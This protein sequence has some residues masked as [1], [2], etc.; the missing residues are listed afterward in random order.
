MDGSLGFMFGF[1][2]SEVVGFE[3]AGKTTSGGDDM[4]ALALS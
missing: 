1:S 2:S 4:S 3:C